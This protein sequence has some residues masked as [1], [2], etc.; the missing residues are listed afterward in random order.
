MRTILRTTICLLCVFVL[1]DKAH[2]Q[3]RTEIHPIETITLTTP[4]FL[5][6]E[7]NAP[8]AVIAG[9]LRIPTFGTDKLPAVVLVHGSGGIS[10]QLTDWAIEL[11]K[12]G[13][14]VFILDSF[15]GR[16]IVSTV[17]DQTLLSNAAMLYDSW[18]ALEILA[19][20]PRID[21]HR[22]VIMGFSKGAVAALYSALTR[23]QKLY[24]PEGLRFAGHIVFYAPCNTS[25][26]EDLITDKTPIRFFHGL[27]DNYTLAEHCREYADKLKQTG[28]DAVFYGYKDAHH[29]F[30]AARLPFPI[31]LPKAI[32]ARKC[33][34]T[35]RPLGS[36]INEE[37]GKPVTAK[38]L[39]IEHGT[40]IAHSAP[41]LEAA[42]KEVAAF[43]KTLFRK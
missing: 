42:R 37:T 29:A 34:F 16:G 23:F 2:A 27:A 13:Y 31:P 26:V 5:R 10:S 25:F 33:R 43:L 38:D 12:Q 20:H 21:P 36:V 24:A 11:N 32:T 7:K 18:R 17:E 4:Q 15:T 22:I 19:K 1:A 3:F 39:C 6:G 35:E 40:T 28:G 9:E 14:A 41:A 8:R 30:D